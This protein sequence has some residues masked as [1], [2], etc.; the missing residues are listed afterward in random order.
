MEVRAED[1]SS[2]SVRITKLEI[3]PG[4]KYLQDLEKRHLALSSVIDEIDSQTSAIHQGASSSNRQR[5]LLKRTVTALKDADGNASDGKWV[6]LSHILH[7]ACTASGS[8]GGGGY[9]YRWSGARPDLAPP[10]EFFD[11][12]TVTPVSSPRKGTRVKAVGIEEGKRWIN[13]RTSAQWQDFEKRF[14]EE[15]RITKKVEQWKKGLVVC[16][17][18]SLLADDSK[19]A[20]TFEESVPVTVDEVLKR[21]A[22]SGK[23]KERKI[24]MTN[25]PAAVSLSKSAQDLLKDA[26]PFGFAVV[27]RQKTVGTTGKPKPKATGPVPASNRDMNVDEGGSGEKGK[28]NNDLLDLEIDG[29][30]FSSHI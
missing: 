13:A 9:G 2:A 26:S 15:R 25:N 14:F 1:T 8:G 30:C 18:Q 22:V 11:P 29:V 19:N 28:K 6:F 17:T 27:K 20:E 4:T 23:G 10:M 24:P 16:G 21:A 7:L 3:R 12:L 5:E